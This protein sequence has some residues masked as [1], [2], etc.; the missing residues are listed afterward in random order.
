MIKNQEAALDMA[1]GEL[2]RFA[3]RFPS[4]FFRKGK[5]RILILLILLALILYNFFFVYVRPN[6]YGIKVVRVGIPRMASSRVTV[7]EAA[8][9]ASQAAIRS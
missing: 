8:T 6:E 2:R 4:G 3:G 9:T 1:A 5:S 7:P